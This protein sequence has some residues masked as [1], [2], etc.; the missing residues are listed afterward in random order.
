MTVPIIPLL[1]CLARLGAFTGLVL[2]A[3]GFVEAD[4]VFDEVPLSR[5]RH[6]I[7]FL[8]VGVCM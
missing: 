2:V 8:P 6:R 1:L 7:K 4:E 3:V 5:F